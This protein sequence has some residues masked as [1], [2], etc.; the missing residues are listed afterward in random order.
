MEIFYPTA[1][2]NSDAILI[3]PTNLA[4]ASLF[5]VSQTELF[6]REEIENAQFP[7]CFEKESLA[8]MPIVCPSLIRYSELP[9]R[10]SIWNR[11]QLSKALW[12]CRYFN[13]FP[14]KWT[15]SNRRPI[16]E[17]IYNFPFWIRR[18]GEVYIRW[19]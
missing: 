2:G 8:R 11:R 13:T 4:C 16:S 5:P 6:R 3:T 19:Q 12:Q 7:E 14:N 1:G 18:R 17:A 9:N 10:S 15:D